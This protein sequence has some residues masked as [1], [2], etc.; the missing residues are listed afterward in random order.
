[1]RIR[2]LPAASDGLGLLTVQAIARSKI[3]MVLLSLP[4]PG[5]HVLVSGPCRDAS[6]RTLV[7][8][9]RIGRDAAGIAL[10]CSWPP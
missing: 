2:L 9:P 4:V 5:A 7:L 1:M 3:F 6:V 8:R 10:G